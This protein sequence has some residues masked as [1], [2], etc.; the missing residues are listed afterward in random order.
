MATIVIN[1]LEIEVP[2]LRMVKDED[3]KLFWF[4]LC[5]PMSDRT[6]GQLFNLCL[7]TTLEG[8][9]VS[10]RVGDYTYKDEFF[11]DWQIHDNGERDER[12]FDITL[13]T[14]E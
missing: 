9:Q 4:D 3:G 13:Y 8:E 1:D 2:H 7:K 5:L 14:L 10:I 12:T 11:L 6:S